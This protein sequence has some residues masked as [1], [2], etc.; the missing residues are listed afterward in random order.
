MPTGFGLKKFGR[1][2][3]DLEVVPGFQNDPQDVSLELHPGVVMGVSE[4]LAAGIRLAV[5]VEGNAWGFTPLLN[6]TIYSART[7]SLFGELVVPVRFVDR[8]EGSRSA[9]GV[10]VHVGIGF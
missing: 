5:D 8:V 7:H 4:G 3:V 2:V 10:G 9:V 6:R 1:F